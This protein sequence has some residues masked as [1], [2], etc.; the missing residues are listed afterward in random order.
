M[1]IRL[2][3][4]VHCVEDVSIKEQVY[5]TRENSIQEGIYKLSKLFYVLKVTF[6]EGNGLAEVEENYSNDTI[7]WMTM[8]T[9][10]LCAVMGY[11]F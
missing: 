3:I 7:V 11:F 2:K 10:L 1:K 6:C 4:N 5:K 8:L 9:K